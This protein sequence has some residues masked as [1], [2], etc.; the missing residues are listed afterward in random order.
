MFPPR[1][2]VA[3]TA[4]ALAAAPGS[5]R[6]APLSEDFNS[7]APTWQTTGLW[8]IQ[9]QP[10]TITVSPL[11]AGILTDVPAGATLPPAWRSTGAAWFGDPLTGTY[12]VGLAA[13]VQHPSDGCR[14]DAPVEGTLTSPPFAVRGSEATLTFLAWWEIAA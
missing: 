11:I 9:D 3:V 8:R 6:A 13:V 14:S 10:Q 5:A 1:V 2:C 4:I 7:G 12:C